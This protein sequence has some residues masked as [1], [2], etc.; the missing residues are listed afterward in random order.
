MNNTDRIN[1]IIK[2]VPDLKYDSSTGIFET[3][4]RALYD[5]AELI[6][7]EFRGVLVD[8]YLNT[9]LEC[10]G[11]FLRLDEAILDHFYGLDDAPK[12]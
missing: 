12:T 1:D 5:F 4:R 9:P 10:C 2:M 3:D 6:I 11:H 8:E 7:A